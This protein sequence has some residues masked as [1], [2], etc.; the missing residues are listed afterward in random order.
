MTHSTHKTLLIALALTAGSALAQSTPPVN[1]GSASTKRPRV[2]VVFDTSSS[3][4]QAPDFAVTNMAYVDDTVSPDPSATADADCRSKFCIAKK[5]V[6][7]QLR[8]HVQ[9]EVAIGLAT[10]YQY[11]LRYEPASSSRCWYDAMWKTGRPLY[12]PRDGAYGVNENSRFAS[13]TDVDLSSSNPMVNSGTTNHYNCTSAT[14]EYDLAEEQSATGTLQTCVVYNLPTSPGATYT[15]AASG[16]P[17]QTGCVASKSY[18]AAFNQN[19]RNGGSYYRWRIPPASTCPATVPVSSDYSAVAAGQKVVVTD[20][21]NNS[22]CSGNYSTCWQSGYVPFGSP[23]SNTC[24]A[25][26]P[27]TMY[28]AASG[29]ETATVSNV[30]WVGYFGG[31]CTGGNQ[32][33]GPNGG[34]SSTTLGQCALINSTST[35]NTPSLGVPGFYD[36]GRVTGGTVGTVTS[37]FNNQTNVCRGLTL[38]VEVRLSGNQSRANYLNRPD[39]II[40][41]AYG[42]ATAGY[43]FTKSPTGNTT[44]NSNWPCDVTLTS[45]TPHAGTPSVS[46]VND[47]TP[48]VVGTTTTTCAPAASVQRQLL[49]TGASC[50]SFAT[51]L[52]SNPAGT[53]ASSPSCGNGTSQCTL[54]PNATPTTTVAMPGCTSPRT[55]WTSAVPATCTY[56]G[57]TGT[58]FVAA[59]GSP[60]AIA[61]YYEFSKATGGTCPANNSVATASYMGGPLTAVNSAY[62]SDVSSCVSGSCRLSGLAQSDSSLEETTTTSTSTSPGTGWVAGSPEY[63]V[64]ASPV[65]TS[66]PCTSYVAG[67]IGPIPGQSGY[68]QFSA[69][70]GFGGST[71][72]GIDPLHPENHIFKCAFYP[73]TYNWT[74]PY[75]RCDYTVTKYTWTAAPTITWCNYDLAR[76]TRTVVTTVYD[77]VYNM[78]VRKFDFQA[79]LYKTCNYYRAATTLTRTAYTYRYL[80][81]TK[82]GELIGSYFTDVP[83]DD[84]CDVAK[85]YSDFSGTCPPTV[86]DCLGSGTTCF[87]RASGASSPERVD[88]SSHPINAKTASGRFSNFSSSLNV[89]MLAPS[90]SAVTTRFPGAPTATANHIGISDGASSG[91]ACLAQDFATPPSTEPARASYCTLAPNLAGTTPSYKLVSDYL[92]CSDPADP[93][94]CVPNSI[95]DINTDPR[96]AAFSLQPGVNPAGTFHPLTA[97]NWTSA[98]TKAY[99]MSGSGTNYNTPS[100]VMMPF[101]PDSASDGNV[102]TFRQMLT[103]CD[104]PVDS[105]VPGGNVTWPVWTTQGVCMPNMG[106]PAPAPYTN[107]IY[108]YTPLYGAL[109]NAHQYIRYELANDANYACRKYFVLLATDGKE[110]T[111]AAKTASDLTSAVTQLRGLTTNNGRSTDVKTFVLG[112]GDQVADPTAAADLNAMANSGGTSGA[113]FATDQASLAVK[114]DQVFA[115]ILAGTYSRSK[116]VISSDGKSIYMSYYDVL[117]GSLEWP[118]HFAAFG[119][120]PTDGHVSLRWELS[121]KLDNKMNDADRSLYTDKAGARENFTVG[122]AAALTSLFNTDADY[123]GGP[124]TTATL[125]P[126]RVLKFVRNT[127]KVTGTAGTGEAY[128]DPAFKRLSRLNAVVTST[129]VVIGRSIN[130][131]DWG[132][133]TS[134]TALTEYSNFQTATSSRETRVMVGSTDGILRSLRD[135]ADVATYSTCPTDEAGAS[136]PNGKEAWGWVPSLLH[137]KLYESLEGYYSGIDGQTAVEDVCAGSGGNARSCVQSDWKTVAISAVRNGGRGLVALDVSDPN[138]PKFMWKFEKTA[139]EDQLGYVQ[140]PIIGRVER[141]ANTD[142]FVAVVA[143]GARAGG[144]SGD[145]GE[146]NGDEIHVLNALD[147]GVVVS[148]TAQDGI[149]NKEDLHGKD[150]QFY[151]RASYF[152]RSGVPQMDNAM[153]SGTSGVLYTMRFREPPTTTTTLGV[154]TITSDPVT[155]PSSWT[156]KIFFDPSDATMTKSPTLA[157][158][159]IRR[160][161]QS[162]TS[163]NFTYSQDPCGGTSDLWSCGDTGHPDTMPLDASRLLPFYLRPR[164]TALYDSNRLTADYYIGTGFLPDPTNITSS[165]DQEYLR[166]YFYAVHDIGATHDGA[167]DGRLMWVNQFIDATEQV[168]SEPAIVNG[169]LIVATYFPPTEGTGCESAGDTRLYCFDPLKGDLRNCLVTADGTTASVVMMPNVGIPS[170]L[171]SANGSLYLTTSN[172]PP[173][174]TPKP[175]QQSVR[176]MSASGDKRSFRRVR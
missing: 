87:L 165:S 50:P 5:T 49:K 74:R 70:S 105:S 119:L 60:T 97:A 17:T 48:S 72:I 56:G 112:F 37:T 160:I 90:A 142:Q 32:P 121:D 4:S 19:D 134:S 98:S 122:N 61:V 141:A 22:V 67:S 68:G 139:S 47:C 38:G 21:T 173:N 30:E 116:P 145:L 125:D 13:L 159:T 174:E 40:Q 6:Y 9:D 115:T 166:N 123:P 71:D 10:Y 155:N 55:T 103:T 69:G 44:C 129:P 46:T 23:V 110:N 34:D 3:M 33:V 172:P 104:P 86:D 65:Y 170:D 63:T 53:W 52:T 113:Y 94:S 95:S 25:G 35:Y 39:A 92:D 158:V 2:L 130:G 117:T 7:T 143:G 154:T 36:S 85:P 62:S 1:P 76:E 100:Q 64:S 157:P 14:S 168:V 89:N 162:G 31:N 124:G 120:D 66:L 132:G 16:L 18:T 78:K 12:Y 27:C 73:V 99:G 11:L 75:T 79:P 80:Y 144:V 8:S 42:G 161:V 28:S 126:L 135:N 88:Y 81:A 151:A 91:L 128:V 118:G 138:D 24:T 107:T 140:A 169:S 57:V 58:P 84:V 147:G 148:F 146:S 82:G 102:D 127:A 149:L 175:I 106:A 167:G 29:S 77:C 51:H 41:T 137:S 164:L 111:P 152:R 176:A 153:L 93:G 83:T 96:P 101:A 131:A 59:G 156:P 45:M 26:T 20:S 150:N 15:T 108:D 163:P 54:T 171:V 136:C 114:L 43:A 133:V 109:E